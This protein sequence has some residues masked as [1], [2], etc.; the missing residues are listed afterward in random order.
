[1]K[2]RINVEDYRQAARKRLPSIAYDYL[3]PGAEDGITCRWNRESFQE[4]EFIPNALRGVGQVDLS[5]RLFGHES[6]LPLVIGPTGFAGLFWPDGDCALASGAA[7]ASIPFVLSTASTTSIED[8][9]SR[10][11]L[12]EAQRWFQLYILNDKN[13]NEAMIRR[14]ETAGYGALVLTIDTPCGGK[15]EASIR[16]GARL[17]LRLDAE[18]VIDFMRHPHWSWS[19]LRHGQPHLA[20]FPSSRTK[21]F[22]METH[23]KRRIDWDD[24]RWLR[25]RWNRPLILKGVQSLEDAVTAAAFGVDGIVLSNHGGRQLDGSRSP[26]Q[27]LEEVAATVGDRMAVMVDSGFRRGGDV[28]KALALGAKAV[29]LGR[30]T[31]YG[32]AACG[33]DGVSDVLSI[34]EDE[35]ARTMTLLGC[36]GIHELNASLIGRR[37]DA[38]R[39][40]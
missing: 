30:A 19:M 39:R 3:E 40:G 12:P 15:R 21:P 5:V 9:A 32:V 35:M 2:K 7:K 10:C 13:A 8:V 22:V 37:A 33:A 17:P 38:A 34:L 20:N 4:L 36:A 11:P 14:A 29:W 23:L 16:H 27:M 18:K 1:M 26:M 28:I 25:S 6:R 31:L 24:V